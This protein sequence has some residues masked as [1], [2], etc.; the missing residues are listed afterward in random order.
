MTSGIYN[1][2]TCALDGP[3]LTIYFPFILHEQ[4]RVIM[5]ITEEF[6]IGSVANSAK[7]RNIA[8]EIYSLYTPVILVLLKKFLTIEE[9]G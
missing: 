5:N 3:S 8:G 4:E 6:D 9:L 7:H 2:L 1:A